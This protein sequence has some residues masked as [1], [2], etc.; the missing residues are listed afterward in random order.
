[1]ELWHLLW[2]LNFESSIIGLKL[3]I[4]FSSLELL[5]A[6]AI[7]FPSPHDTDVGENRLHDKPKECLC[8]RKGD[9]TTILCK[10]T[11]SLS[12]FYH[13]KAVFIYTVHTP[14]FILSL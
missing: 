11:I 12:Q 5:L 9:R 4:A 3:E 8:V 1:M 14:C 2:H 7:C 6:R 10:S 13:S